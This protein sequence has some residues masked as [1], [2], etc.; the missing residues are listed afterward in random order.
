[1]KERFWFY[2]RLLFTVLGWAAIATDIYLRII[3]LDETGELFISVFS[4]WRTFTIQTN[5]L[6][7][8]FWTI[9]LIYFN[10]DK[11]PF[12]LRPAVK[13]AIAVYI[14][15]IFLSYEFILGGLRGLEGSEFIL[16]LIWHY[17]IPPAFVVDYLLYT[18]RK[19]IRFGYIGY[20]M[21]YPLCYSI[22]LS[23]SG[24][25]YHNYLYS[26]QNVE[27]LGL[28]RVLIYGF[29]QLLFFAFL[30]FIYV[31]LNRRLPGHISKRRER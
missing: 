5:L 11:E 31:L 2:F 20:W 29:G 14:T 7:L 13:G 8:L 6:I 22:Y 23:I 30:G 24:F 18:K 16:S 27:Q 25:I 26:F 12:F 4:R 28:T 3:R 21:I 10:K 1:M 17:V 9:S 15:L 19:S